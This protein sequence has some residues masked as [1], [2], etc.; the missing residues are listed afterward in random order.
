MSAVAQLQAREMRDSRGVPTI[1][2]DVRLS[3]GSSARAAAPSGG[4]R[5]RHEAR[6]LRDGDELRYEGRGVRQAVENVQS[7]I[8][9]AI[10]GL[11]L[12][13]P[14]TLDREPIALDCTDDRSR[15]GCQH[16]LGSVHRR[17]PRACR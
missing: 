9:P 17:H 6:E 3:D 8:A 4:S 7:V 16:A 12:D 1:E 15:L 10:V 11:E 5:G 14:W 2:V 13:G